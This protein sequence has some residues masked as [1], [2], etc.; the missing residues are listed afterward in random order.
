MVLFR[1][2]ESG[3]ARKIF[4]SATGPN[5]GKTTLCFALLHLARKKY[6][7]VGF[8]KPVGPKPM[9]LRG[10]SMDKDAA[11]MAQVFDLGTDLRSMSPVVLH[12]GSTR[13]MVDGKVTVADLESRI[14][15]ACDKLD[16]SCEFLI[17]EGTGHAGVGSILKLSNARVARMLGAPTL[18]VTGGGIG[19]VVD[20][21]SI[22]QALFEKEGAEVR[23]VLVNKLIPEK[24]DATLDYLRRALAQ[25]SF[26]LLGGFNYQPILANPTLRRI[27]R[28]L[29]LPLHGNQS[30]DGRIIH[31]VQIGAA[32]TQRVAELLEESSLLIVT[33]SRDELLVTLANLYQLPDYHSKI[34]GVVIPGIIPIGRITQQILDR[35]NIPY[36]RTQTHTTAELHQIITDDVSK[37]TPEDTQKLAL[38]RELAELH[39]DF[40]SLDALFY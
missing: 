37:L 24:R 33:S 40:E 32:S 6:R 5:I 16:R 14:I 17:I 38:V 23:A 13:E 2:L 39:F 18:M 19:S 1:R 11:L 34:V 30:E 29:D 31:H 3:M 20:S 15:E 25:E 9:L 4:I 36:L 8:I 27:A 21:V 10:V 22:N 35:S 7:R 26:K 12:R 28:L